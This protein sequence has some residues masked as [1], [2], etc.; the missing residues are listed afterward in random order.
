M[1]YINLY[2]GNPYWEG[3][4]ETK[5]TDYLS[6]L[7]FT[8]K[9]KLDDDESLTIFGYVYFLAEEIPTTLLHLFK[10][11]FSRFCSYNSWRQRDVYLGCIFN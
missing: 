11:D 3:V 10:N 1:Q 8:K 2:G 6:Y 5:S 7:P 4:G 9:T